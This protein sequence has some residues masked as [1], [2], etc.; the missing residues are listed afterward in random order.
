[1]SDFCRADRRRQ[2]ATIGCHGIDVTFLFI[3]RGCQV[4]L[5]EIKG[6]RETR[7]GEGHE[8]G[9]RKKEQAIFVLRE[10]KPAY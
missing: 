6:K 4:G 2:R 5:C 9:I 3:R 7:G 10:G 8:R 1:M